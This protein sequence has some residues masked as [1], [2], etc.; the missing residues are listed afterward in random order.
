LHFRFFFVFFIF[1]CF[2]ELRYLKKD[3][4]VLLG[5]PREALQNTLGDFGLEKYRADQIEDLLFRGAKS[6]AELSQLPKIQRKILQEADVITG[7]SE[8]IHKVVSS[9]G[10][11][12]LLLKLFDG[13]VIETVGIPSEK[14]L[15][16]CVSSQIG[17]T[18]A[19][20]FCAT[21][22]RNKKKKKKKKKHE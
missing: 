12:K 14:R 5:L 15:T 10:T 7:R 17:C 21:G 20:S 9:D 19:C 18:M 4:I 1:C 6:I 13:S 3:Q 11:T 22:K 16:I 8:L 2:L